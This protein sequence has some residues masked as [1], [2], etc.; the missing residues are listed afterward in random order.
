MGKFTV[1]VIVPN[2]NNEKYLRQCLDSILSQ[3]YTIKELII[4][5]DCST[6]AS[7][8]ILKEYAEKYKIVQVIYGEKNVGV[9][10]ARDI[11]IQ[12]T[13]SDY[14]CMLDADDFFYSKKKLT[15]EMEKIESEFHNTG[16]MV[17]SFSQTVDVDE[18]GRPFGVVERK[19]LT[20]DE[21]FK[22]V[23]RLYNN[24]MPR[25]YCFPR[26]EYNAVGGYT[27]GLSL[28]E[29]WELNIKLLEKVN[30]VYSGEYGTA[31]RH[32]KNGL[33]SANYKTQLETKID[34]FKKYKMSMKEK[35][36][37]YILAYASFLKHLIRG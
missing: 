13:T 16:K 22:I 17:V 19:D 5:D 31:Y 9:S 1:S 12:S 28:F 21:R 34:I 3:T 27:K 25:D 29:D 2:Y 15:A 23:T 8:E 30:F 35:I 24:F 7:K 6:D 36:V 26:E 18:Y 33:S 37:F 4:Y 11:A 20:G 14:V 10:T 32:K